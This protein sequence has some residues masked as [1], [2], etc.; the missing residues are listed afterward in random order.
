MSVAGL[1]HSCI[2]CGNRVSDQMIAHAR[3][4]MRPAGAVCRACLLTERARSTGRAEAV[5]T[6]GQSHL[7]VLAALT[8]VAASLTCMSFD[9][10]LSGFAGLLF[11]FLALAI[12]F[13]RFFA[14]EAL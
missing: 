13:L 6:E 5:Q 14:P 12:V 1:K 8:M 4:E 7:L 11:G 3:A 9:S 2:R 10:F